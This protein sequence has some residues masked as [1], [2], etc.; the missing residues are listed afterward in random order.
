MTGAIAILAVWRFIM[1]TLV[2]GMAG[3]QL[4]QYFWT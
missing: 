2:A 3:L 4:L 1:P